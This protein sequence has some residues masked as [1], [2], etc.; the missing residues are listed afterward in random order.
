M[1]RGGFLLILDGKTTSFK[2]YV[3]PI[4]VPHSISQFLNPLADTD[5]YTQ[6]EVVWV[7]IPNPEILRDR[8]QTPK[9]CRSLKLEFPQTTST[10]VYRYWH[11]GKKSFSE[12]IDNSHEF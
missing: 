4:A 8:D 11:R 6:N 1:S 7:A 12:I 5:S 3:V 10:W 2:L 9:P